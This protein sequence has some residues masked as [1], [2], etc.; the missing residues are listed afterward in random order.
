MI[1]LSEKNKGGRPTSNPRPHKISVRISDESIKILDEYCEEKKIS[2][3]DG[4][5]ESIN[6]LKNKK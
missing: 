2:R 5:R 1:E 3:A 6:S 4:V